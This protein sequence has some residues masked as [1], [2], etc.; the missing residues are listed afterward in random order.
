MWFIFELLQIIGVSVQAW[1]DGCLRSSVMKFTALAVF[2][3]GA[4]LSGRNL[5]STRRLVYKIDYDAENKKFLDDREKKVKDLEKRN[6]QELKKMDEDFGPDND[7]FAGSLAS[8]LQVDEDQVDEDY[9]AL[10]N[11]VVADTAKAQEGLHEY[12][13]T[14]GPKTPSS[15]EQGAATYV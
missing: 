6:V 7:K 3:C 2:A 8:D 14:T 5:L 13:D 10:K 9:T 1:V 12:T 4:K 15:T 11:K